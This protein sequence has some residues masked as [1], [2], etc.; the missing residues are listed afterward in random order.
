MLTLP[1][2]PNQYRWIIPLTLFI[3]LLLQLLYIAI[4]SRLP[5]EREERQPANPYFPPVRDYNPLPTAPLTPTPS[6]QPTAVA[7]V[8]SSRPAP[9]PAYTPPTPTQTPAPTAPRPASGGNL[10]KMVVLTGIENL[11]DVPIPAKEFGIGRF[12]SPE[13]DVLVGLDEKSISRKHARFMSDE[14]VREYYIKD[15]SSSFGTFLLINGQFQQLT[16]NHQERVYNEDVLRFGNVVTVRLQ[17]PCET[18]SA[19]TML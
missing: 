18:R 7:P 4:L 11:T 5:K 12:Y 6:V 10:G 9:A 17:I 13:S 8:Q 3:L 14:G 15:T 2:D 19:V 1:L 16:A